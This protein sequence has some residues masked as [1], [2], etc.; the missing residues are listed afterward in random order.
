MVIRDLLIRWMSERVFLCN[1]EVKNAYVEKK[2]IVCERVS[3][4][5]PSWP[6]LLPGE[7]AARGIVCDQETE[8]GVTADDTFPGFDDHWDDTDRPAHYLLL[9]WL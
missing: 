1:V 8:C 4:V 6:D 3:H 2:K 5:V 9:R 7:P